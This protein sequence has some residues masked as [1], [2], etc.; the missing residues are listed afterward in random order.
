MRILPLDDATSATSGGKAAALATLRHAGFDVPDGFVIPVSEY[1]LHQH[2][3]ALQTELI[4]AIGVH[5]RL[6]FGAEA[7]GYVAVRSSASDEDGRSASA[8]G[9][10]D[11]VLAVRGAADVAAAVQRCWSSLNSPRAVSYRD[12]QTAAAQPPAMAVLVQPFIDADVSGVL[13]TRTPRT[14]EAV[15]GL[16]AP[17]V[18]GHVTPDAWVLDDTG[19]TGRHR[20]HPTHRLDRNSDRLVTTPLQGRSGMCLTDAT[21]IAIDHH[22][23]AVA[24]ALGYDADIEW[25][26]TGHRL[27]TL[28]ARPITAPLAS[29]LP[30]PAEEADADARSTMAIR[31]RQ[32]ASH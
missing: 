23:Q 9:Q 14:I 11:T 6:L 3:T 8:A 32:P 19:V 30:C 5:L 13:F 25:A 1:Q 29:P 2:E 28:Q 20:G 15:P 17:L 12:P 27:H 16:G 7:E 22:G 18:S 24:E 4:D 21:A 10:H 31:G 26:L